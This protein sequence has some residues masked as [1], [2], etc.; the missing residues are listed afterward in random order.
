MAV[1]TAHRDQLVTFQSID[2]AITQFRMEVMDA[3]ETVLKTITQPSADFRVS[4]M[5]DGQAL[6][7]YAFQVQSRNSSDW[8]DFGDVHSLELIG[9]PVPDDPTVV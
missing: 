4:V 9:P 6:G 3:T 7:S 2:P 8:G 1:L 5:L